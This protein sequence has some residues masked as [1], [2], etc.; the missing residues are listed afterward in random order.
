MEHGSETYRLLTADTAAGTVLPQDGGS[1]VPPAG[2]DPTY[3]GSSV[4]VVDDDEITC[5]LI[6]HY[7]QELGANVSLAFTGE[8][9][10]RIMAGD[11]VDLM[12]LDV[13]LPDLSGFEV[14]TRVKADPCS[15]M[16]PVVMASG[17]GS[18][19]DRIEGLRAGASDFLVKPVDRAE[20]IARVGN[21]LDLHRM[22]K[23]LEAERI[24]RLAREVDAQ[25]AIFQ[26]YMSPAVVERIFSGDPEHKDA[27]ATR[28]ERLEAA[29][30]FADLRGFTSMAESLSP[31]DVVSLLN[32]YFAHMTLIVHRHG[33]TIFHMAGDALMVGF[34]VPFVQ[35][36]AVARALRA[37][38][39]M[40]AESGPAFARWPVDVGLG[41]G[42]NVG[43]VVAGN[44]GSPDYMSYT[45]IGDA[46]NVA[47]RLTA[48]A[49]AGEILLSEEVRFALATAGMNM[50]LIPVP[51]LTLKGKA[52]P[53]QAWALAVIQR[54]A[55]SETGVQA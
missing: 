53:V 19:K 25:R 46:V 28:N 3:A 34:G 33:G 54:T 24:G 15:A 9:A 6:A 37:G 39:E 21:L 45:L 11:G 26:R 29:V 2:A 7:L 8:D 12:I 27:L 49:R 1:V 5:K 52:Q 10:L 42:I 31:H 23:A 38:Q 48:R 16:V 47:A 17:L 36:D 40:I 43:E 32:R 20:L 50:P 18:R 22:R 13:L 55:R 30:L 14:C 41:V 4:L 35:S 44:I 51:P